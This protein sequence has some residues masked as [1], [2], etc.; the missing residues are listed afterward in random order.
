MLGMKKKQTTSMN[1]SIILF[2][3]TI[4]TCN[5][6]VMDKEESDK[7]VQ[8]QRTHWT[9]R[10]NEDGGVQRLYT[11]HM[12]QHST[13]LNSRFLGRKKERGEGKKKNRQSVCMASQ[14]THLCRKLC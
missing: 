8:R 14:L 2:F 5:V 10:L 13:R 11:V 12:S 7:G 3:C 4:A 6:A 9:A 1:K